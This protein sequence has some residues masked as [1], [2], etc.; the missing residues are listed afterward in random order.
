[1]HLPPEQPNPVVGLAREFD[2]EMQNRR[3]YD[4][5]D[6][7]GLLPPNLAPRSDRLGLLLLVALSVAVKLL[8][9]T[10]TCAV[11][12]DGYGFIHT[13]QRMQRGSF[14]EVV[15]STQ[16]H[17]L[18]PAWLVAVSGP[19]HSVGVWDSPR[20]WELSGQ[21]AAAVSGILLVWPI[22]GIGRRI[23]NR[24]VGFW[25][26]ALFSVLPVPSRVLADC[27]SDST[28][29]LFLLV[30]LNL[31]LRAVE[32]RRAGWWLV[33][34]GCAGMAYLTRPEGLLGGACIVLFVL[35]IQLWP[36]WRWPR[37]QLLSGAAGVALLLLMAVLPYVLLVGGISAKQSAGT[38]LHA[39]AL[40][41][42]PLGEAMLAVGERFV[43]ANSYV[44]A[45]FPLVAWPL[46]RKYTRRSPAHWLALMQLLGTLIALT[47]LSWK[48]GYVSHRHVLAAVVISSYWSAAGI[49]IVSHY[50][51]RLLLVLLERTRWR[52]AAEPIHR[53]LAAIALL[54][55]FGCCATSLARPL[56]YNRAAHLEVAQWLVRH[57]RPDEFV[58]DLKQIASFRAQRPY[59]SLQRS[60]Q[61][62]RG[63]EHVLRYLITQEDEF[64]A[65]SQLDRIYLKLL[66]DHGERLVEFPAEPKPGIN[67]V[68]V[69]RLADSAT[70]VAS[71][72]PQTRRRLTRRMQRAAARTSDR[73]W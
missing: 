38:L 60:I 55:A 70:T 20:A 1:M 37:G 24:V 19:V 67:R 47:G 68:A 26:T 18:Y 25:G 4:A 65:A 17:P 7:D 59:C 43:R 50:A 34:A 73:V 54:L 9:I 15:R 56:H 23:F 14:W 63:G 21:V 30:S 11:A 35:A 6:L 32:N 8:V 61:V 22:Y 36:E 28:Y 33:A 66:L 16:Q 41:V 46:T 13:A 53:A 5:A 72:W 62:A 12:T 58:I 44:F 57:T 42:R 48:V 69:Y 49:L 71:R 10:R 29:L 39:A 3:S 31:V 64:E 2:R 45:L 51:A 40:P 27:L 52:I